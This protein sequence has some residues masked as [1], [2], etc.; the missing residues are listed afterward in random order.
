[1]HSCPL[2][3]K[4]EYHVC[5]VTREVHIEIMHINTKHVKEVIKILIV[6]LHFH[7]PSHG[8]LK[9]IVVILPQFWLMAK[10]FDESFKWH[11][12]IINVQ[13]YYLKMI[14]PCKVCVP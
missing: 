8:V 10:Y 1:M 9:G 7:F 14:K 11:I 5:Y 13:H 12:D 4:Y 6:E 3:H 2:S